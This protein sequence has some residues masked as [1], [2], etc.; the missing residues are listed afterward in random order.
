LRRVGSP[1]SP[2]RSSTQRALIPLDARG[3][4]LGGGE[5]DGGLPRTSSIGQTTFAV[6]RRC[7]S[8]PASTMPTARRGSMLMAAR[9]Q[10]AER[11]RRDAP[12][13]A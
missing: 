1:W 11:V 9:C 8:I 2:G 10:P 3:P 6:S 5:P 13:E 4:D 7:S 12:T